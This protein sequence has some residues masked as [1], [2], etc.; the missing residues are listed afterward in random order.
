MVE[1]V[2]AY[3]AKNATA[4]WKALE[5]A[6]RGTWSLIPFA[7]HSPGAAAGFVRSM[8]LPSIP[9]WAVRRERWFGFGDPE[10]VLEETTFFGGSTRVVYRVSGGKAVEQPSG[11]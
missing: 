9:A 7:S 8:Q 11:N 6:E 1:F 10:W 4:A 3:E 5:R 2:E